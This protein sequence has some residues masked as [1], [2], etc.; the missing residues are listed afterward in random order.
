MFSVL[1][2]AHVAGVIFV[3]IAVE[4]TKAFVNTGSVPTRVVCFTHV[5]I[6]SWKQYKHLRPIYSERKE[7]RKQ[8]LFQMGSKIIQCDAHIEQ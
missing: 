8:R 1:T 6:Q 3:A 2:L 7:T 5:H 4:L